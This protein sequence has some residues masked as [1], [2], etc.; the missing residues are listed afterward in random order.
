MVR[1]FSARLDWRDVE[2]R[3]E[4]VRGALVYFVPLAGWARDCSISY[5]IDPTFFPP[6]SDRAEPADSRSRIHG[7]DLAI[8]RAV[9]PFPRFDVAGARLGVEF[10]L[11]LGADCAASAVAVRRRPGA[12]ARSPG[13]GGGVPAGRAVRDAG[14]CR[15]LVGD[16][17][18]DARLAQERDVSH[19]SDRCARAGTR[20]G[21]AQAPARSWRRS[22]PI[23]SCTAA[24]PESR[25]SSSCPR[26]RCSRTRCSTGGTTRG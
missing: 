5:T 17:R 11:P 24:L 21:S 1:A 10:D 6:G 2:V 16:P 20:R 22:S 8:I 7:A 23:C 12:G 26:R 14:C 19:R 13:G 15:R 3:P 25:P 18:R 4:D 9:E